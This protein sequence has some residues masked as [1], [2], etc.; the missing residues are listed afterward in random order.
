LADPATART[1]AQDAADVISAL[2]VVLW[3]IIIIGLIWF[4]RVPVVDLV[5]SAR[6]RS[7]VIKI[8]GQEL[9]MDEA[10]QQQRDLIAD[11]QKQIN[12]VKAHLGIGASAQS[13]FET[14]SGTSDGRRLSSLLWV[15]DEPKNNAYLIEQL[16]RSDVS[17]DS[18]GS[19]AEALSYLNRKRYDVIISDMGRQEGVR[20]NS[21]AG[22]D[23]LR[24]VRQIDQQTPFILF[25]SSQS[26]AKHRDE[27]MTEKATA[28][29]ASPTDLLAL[30]HFADPTVAG[31]QHQ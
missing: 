8:G 25:C 14:P 22:L 20:Y 3:P 7:F 9:S 18:V 12:D 28:I 11:L 26:V 19:T 24:A 10:S 21:K 17:I 2:A 5:R 16:T 6:S 31:A 13:S 27:A 1:I 30:L 15:D 4:L 29:T 23:L